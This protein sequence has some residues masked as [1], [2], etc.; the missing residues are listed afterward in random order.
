[1]PDARPRN[2]VLY[3]AMEGSCPFESFLLGLTDKKFKALIEKRI[4]K[5]RLGLIGTYDKVGDGIIEL[6][7]DHGPGFRIYCVD[8]GKETLILT[9]GDKSTQTKDIVCAKQ[10]W[11]S[12][13]AEDAQK[14]L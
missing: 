1:M 9:A 3:E 14:K 8:D 5:I 2:V 6:K 10:F 13:K 11:A 7:L 4:A 12:V